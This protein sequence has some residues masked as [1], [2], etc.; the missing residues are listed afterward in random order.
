MT[1]TRC[2]RCSTIARSWLMNSSARP[3]SL[4]QVGEQVDDLRLDRN[5][6]RRD[7]L[8]ADD[9]VGAGRERAG[10]ADALALA[11]RELVREAARRRRAAGRTCVQQRRNPVVDLAPGPREAEIEQRLGDD[12]A[13]PQARIEAAERVLEHDLHPP[14]HGRSSARSTG[15]RCARRR[16]GPR[17]RS[18][19]SAAGRAAR[20]SICR[21]RSRRR[22]DSVSPRSMVKLTPSTASR[23]ARRPKMPAQREML[24]DECHR[25]RAAAPSRRRR[26]RTRRSGRRRRGRTPSPRAAGAR[27]RQMSAASGQRAAKAQPRRPAA[28][29]AR[30]PGS[31]RACC[32]PCRAATSPAAARR[33]AGRACRDA[34]GSAK[35]AATGAVLDL[36]AGIHHDDPLGHFGDDAEVVGDQHDRRAE[37]A[38]AARAS[39]RG[40]APGW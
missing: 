17:R 7:R 12:V 38:L 33:R 23:T 5:V 10:D 4:L 27:A 22:R 32:P 24:L 36:A 11:A 9:Q 1:A 35:I 18:A 20:R 3:S 25:P 2:V 6:E 19:G 34:A 26:L 29:T 30:C 28:A 21:S 8:V 16:G 15:C 40:S 13:H 39:D 14:P 37:P 31:R